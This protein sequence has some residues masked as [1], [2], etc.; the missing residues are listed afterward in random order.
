MI[1]LM[2]GKIL[3]LVCVTQN[4]NSY[5]PLQYVKVLFSV[6]GHFW[7]FRLGVLV[8]LGLSG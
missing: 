6:C 8:G 1:S 5:L 3:M 7:F 2:Q 4:M